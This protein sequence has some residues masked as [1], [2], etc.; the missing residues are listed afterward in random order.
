MEKIKFF[1]RF[2]P[3]PSPGLKCE[4]ASLTRQ[5]FV[6]ESDL[7]NIMKRYAA[8]MPLPTGA[9]PPIFDDFTNIPDY[10][11]SFDI[12]ARSQ[13]LFMQL[14]SEVRKRFDNDP[15]SLLA[16]LNDEKN[17]EE[18]QKLGLLNKPVEKSVE[19]PVEKPV[20]KSVSVPVTKVEGE[21]K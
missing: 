14:P 7:N 19:T 9:R 2:N 5:E 15:M 17:R 1:T 12:V 6:Q 20:E 13:E 8:G 3:P 18:A 16:F 4:D 10:Q 11:K 21:T